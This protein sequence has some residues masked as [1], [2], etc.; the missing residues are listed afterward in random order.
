MQTK[1]NYVKPSECNIDYHNLINYA[2]RLENQDIPMHS[3]IIM[4]GNNICMESYYKPYDNNSLH[5]M[6]SMTKSLVSLGI[7]CL[8]GEHKLSLDDHIVDYFKDKLPQNGAYDYMKMLTIRD[9]LTMRTW[10]HSLQSSLFTHLAHNSLM[11]LHQ[12]TFLV[13]LLKDYL[14]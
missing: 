1:F 3:L 9:M 5:R 14:E 7:G 10:A 8:Y 13:L 4:R 12:L 6:F 11:T 2:K